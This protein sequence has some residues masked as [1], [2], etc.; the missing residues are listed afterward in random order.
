M[1]ACRRN[2][3]YR[4]RT[5]FPKE[6]PKKTSFAQTLAANALRNSLLAESIPI[7]DCTVTF[8]S[9]DRQ[10]NALLVASS[11]EVTP[12]EDSVFAAIEREMRSVSLNRRNEMK[13]TSHNRS[14]TAPYR[15]HSKV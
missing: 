12:P 7:N 11:D 15:L 13:L 5:D 2:D 9:I 10:V 3:C 14:H 6:V 8:S 4:D 1:G